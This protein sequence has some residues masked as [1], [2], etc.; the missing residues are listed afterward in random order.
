MFAERLKSLRSAKKMTQKDL[1]ALLHVSH[2]A[3]GKYERGEA[4]PSPEILSKL[5]EIFDT[6]TD[7]L[8]GRAD[9]I[10]KEPTLDTSERRL[11]SPY[12]TLN[13]ANKAIVDR[14]IDDLIKTQ[15]SD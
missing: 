4:L 9:E 5:A 12:Q 2:Q 3:V 11:P 1:G 8:L 7:Y 15:S 13:E 6:S 10:K 14:L